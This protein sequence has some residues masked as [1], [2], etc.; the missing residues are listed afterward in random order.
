MEQILKRGSAGQIE[1]LPRVDGVVDQSISNA[2]CAIYTRDGQL[3][4]AAS[5][6][7]IAADGIISMTMDESDT[8]EL[9]DYARAEF[10]YVGSAG[11]RRY[12][13]YFHIAEHTFELDLWSDH[14]FILAPWLKNRAGD[15]DPLF[16]EGREAARRQLYVRLLNAGRQPW[17]IVNLSALDGVF[18]LLWISISC[19]QISADIDDIWS[20]RAQEYRARFEDEFDRLNILEADGADHGSANSSPINRSKLRRA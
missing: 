6:C 4:R 11:F 10:T 3:L 8:E 16:S 13:E 1:H 7:S 15:A 9:L 2:A 19:E 17:K 14:L 20:R 18:T 12:D 5:T